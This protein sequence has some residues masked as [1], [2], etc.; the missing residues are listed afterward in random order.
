MSHHAV[1]APQ[2][3][4][5][6]DPDFYFGMVAENLLRSFGDRALFYADEALQKMKMMGDDDGLAMWV[7]IHAHITERAGAMLGCDDA[8]RG[9]QVLH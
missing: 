7:S 2:Q 4:L 3:G 6:F 5:P 9:S 8:G 1:T